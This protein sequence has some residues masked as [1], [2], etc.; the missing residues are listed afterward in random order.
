MIVIGRYRDWMPLALLFASFLL[1]A[2]CETAEPKVTSIEIQR[3]D[4]VSEGGQIKFRVAPGD[5]L[6]VIKSQTC[7]YGHD[8]CW[9]V[10]NTKTGE[11][12]YVQADKMKKWHRVRTEGQ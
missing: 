5:V 4:T 2:A 7:R 6:K 1:L 10:E 12:G 8:E 9:E 11:I 3:P